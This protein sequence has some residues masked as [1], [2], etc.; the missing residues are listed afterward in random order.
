MVFLE[1]L[2]VRLPELVGWMAFGFALGYPGHRPREWFI[3]I[4]TLTIIL[5]GL[6]LLKP[7]ISDIG[8][9]AGCVGMTAGALVGRRSRRKKG[10]APEV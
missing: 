6:Y 4:G 9:G 8:L 10:L 7:L 2:L 5:V 3:A 1:Q